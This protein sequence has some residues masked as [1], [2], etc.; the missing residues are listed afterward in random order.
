MGAAVFAAFLY[1][2]GA[3]AQD[4]TLTSRDGALAISGTL[5]GYDGEIFRISSAYG[6]LTIDGQGVT[7]AGPACPDLL[8]PKAVI[9]IT[10]AV[11]AGAKLLPHSRGR[12]V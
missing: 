9:A 7:C 1:P 12:V 10:G 4:V 6:P 3:V 11:D 5:S 2:V 8:A